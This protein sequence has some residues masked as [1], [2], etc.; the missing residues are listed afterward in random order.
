M[1][2]SNYANILIEHPNIR[3]NSIIYYNNQKGSFNQNI[4]LSKSHWTAVTIMWCNKASHDVMWCHK[5][6][7]AV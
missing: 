4:E 5:T 7:H 3:G 1:L 2:I 6:S